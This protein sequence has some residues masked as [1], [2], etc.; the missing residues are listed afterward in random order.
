VEVHVWLILRGA[1]ALTTRAQLREFEVPTIQTLDEVIGRFELFAQKVFEVDSLDAV[2]PEMVS[3]FVY[4][5]TVPVNRTWQRCTFAALRMFFRVARMHLGFD[6][7]RMVL[8]CT[9]TAPNAQRT[10]E[11]NLPI[12]A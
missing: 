8:P 1:F 3:L 11:G 5:K 6:G 10:A 12:A 4:A 7:M 9:C 2:T